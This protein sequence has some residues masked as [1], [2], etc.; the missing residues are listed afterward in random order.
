M[1]VNYFDQHMIDINISEDKIQRDKKNDIDEKL[2]IISQYDTEN[3][4]F[5]NHTLK[6]AVNYL[7]QPNIQ[8]T[9]YLVNEI[10]NNMSNET[11][12][13]Y[14]DSFGES[15]TISE[16]LKKIASKVKKMIIVG[17]HKTRAINDFIFCVNIR[18]VQK[19]E[20][21]VKGNDKIQFGF[22]VNSI[23]ATKYYYSRMKKYF[24]NVLNQLNDLAV[25]ELKADIEGTCSKILLNV[26]N[27]VSHYQTNMANIK[28]KKMM[29]VYS[30]LIKVIGKERLQ[31]QVMFYDLDGQPSDMNIA[32]LNSISELIY[33]YQLSNDEERISY[34]YD[35][36]SE[37][38]KEE[39]Q[40]LQYCHFVNNACVGSRY[41]SQ[42]F[43][44]SK[45]NGCCANTYLDKGK[46]CRYLKEDYSCSICSISCRVFTCQY[47]QERGIDHALWQ[48]PLMDC[49]IRLFYRHRVV[50]DFFVPEERML[51]RL[52]H[53][54]Q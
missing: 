29:V 54:I 21:L 11:I 14:F 46:N 32:M 10:P 44:N 45:E 35:K 43:P 4:S 41:G 18:N 7:F 3:A 6:K 40:K 47:L 49:S 28:L 39:A 22:H 31:N 30:R 52:K 42:S 23:D 25:K 9:N 33:V 48:Y 27:F 36:I 8:N 16:Q 53:G 2:D 38:M 17:N 19:I 26:N 51:Q 37:Q 5:I 1:R 34:V 13:I 12:I 50:W 24:L 15:D 20:K